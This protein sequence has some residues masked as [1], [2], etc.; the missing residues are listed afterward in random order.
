MP[1]LTFTAGSTKGAEGT[2]ILYRPYLEIPRKQEQDS[3]TLVIFNHLKQYNFRRMLLPTVPF[4]ID[5][6][7]ELVGVDAMIP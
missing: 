7:K 4:P 6:L 5:K 3:E 1:V 2:F